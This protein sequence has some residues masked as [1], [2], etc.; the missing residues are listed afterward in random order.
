MQPVAGSR[1]AGFAEKNLEFRTGQRGL[2]HQPSCLRTSSGWAWRHSPDRFSRM[3][4][5]PC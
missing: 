1:R 3:Y 4:G 2:D 5:N